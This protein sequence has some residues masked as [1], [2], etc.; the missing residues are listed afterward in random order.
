MDRDTIMT[1]VVGLI[2]C[3]GMTGGVLFL[4]VG[5]IFKLP[6][7]INFATTVCGEC[8]ERPP[9]LRKPADTYEILW[10]GWTCDQ[11]GCKNDKWGRPRGEATRNR[12]KKKRQRD[13]DE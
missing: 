5:T 6:F 10:G 1:I 4:V 7:G 3:G 11:C 12:R 8:G 9:E 13:D 2:C